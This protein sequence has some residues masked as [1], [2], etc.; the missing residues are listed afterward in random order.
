MESPDLF[1]ESERGVFP[2]DRKLP[3]PGL[4]S[5]ESFDIPVAVCLGKKDFYRVKLIWD[6]EYGKDRFQ[7]QVISF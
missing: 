5:G 6:D 1:D 4:I 2:D 3:Y 7:E